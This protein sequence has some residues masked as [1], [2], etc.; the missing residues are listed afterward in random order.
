M[1]GNAAGADRQRGM[2][3]RAA[4]DEPREMEGRAADEPSGMERR[5]LAE[6]QRG[7]ERIAEAGERQG[8]ASDHVGAAGQE[9]CRC[10]PC[11]WP[12]GCSAI[13]W[14][15]EDGKHL[16]GRNLDF[17]KLPMGAKVVYMPAGT[18]F[19]TSGTK[20]EGNLDEG[21]RQ[22]AEHSVLGIGITALG[23]AP[24]FYEGV[25]E[26]GLMGGQL[27]YRELASFAET[28]GSGRLPVQPPLAVTYL[29]ASCATVEEAVQALRETVWLEGKPL[30]GPVP[31]LHWM[32]SDVS[33]ACAIIEPDRDGLHIYRQTMGVMANSPG[34][35]WHRMNLLNYSLLGNRDCIQ[36]LQMNGVS[37]EQ[38]FSG[39]GC[40]GLPGDFTSPSRFVRL[41]FLRQ[42]CE[43]GRDEP[44]GV[45]YLFRMLQNV[46]FPL[47]MVYVGEDEAVSAEDQGVTTYDYTVY[48]AAMCGESGRYY[49]TTYENGRVQYAELRDFQECRQVVE[50]DLEGEADF[51]KRSW[52]G[53]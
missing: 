18:V 7:T 40:Q 47:G 31:P 38:C 30:L 52:R 22:T 20:L 51:R 43:K 44:Q 15:T 3:R 45:A 4:A 37:V 16:W 1:T 25:N 49:W 42:F 39:T 41:A 35:P 26:A 33:G 24:V 9:G 48:T 14:E 13:A 32:F 8:T 46:A 10:R 12:S 29:L 2:E 19:Y 21:S 50:L 53:R 27:Y 5:P 34:Y 28:D 11:V 6:R 36:P 17:N 23:S